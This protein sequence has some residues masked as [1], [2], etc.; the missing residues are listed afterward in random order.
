[1]PSLVD[2]CLA[3]FIRQE[4]LGAVGGIPRRLLMWPWSDSLPAHCSSRSLR[5]FSLSQ[6]L[7]HDFLQ[8]RVESL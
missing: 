1:M 3:L 7:A 8:P 5:I 6:Q 2:H 4:F